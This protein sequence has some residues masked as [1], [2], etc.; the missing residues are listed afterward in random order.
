MMPK[1]MTNPRSGETSIGMT[2]LKR[3]PPPVHQCWPAAGNL[4]QIMACQLPLAAAKAAPQSPPM[5]AWL[6]LDGRPKYQVSKFQKIAASS[7]QMSICEEI[8]GGMNL[9]STRPE[10][11][12]LATAAR[13]E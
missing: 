12:V 8:S 1:A 4:L 3:M 6:E 13:S 5:S 11:M 10:A 7:A 2:T 9:V